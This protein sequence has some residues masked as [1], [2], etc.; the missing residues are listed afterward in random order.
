MNAHSS[1]SWLTHTM[2]ES[3]PVEVCASCPDRQPRLSIT[4]LKF[5]AVKRFSLFNRSQL[6][7]ASTAKVRA[8]LR[9]GP[10]MLDLCFLPKSGEPSGNGSPR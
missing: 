2:E 10:R 5:A 1:N 3:P 8:I 4:W 7:S 6:D 9:A